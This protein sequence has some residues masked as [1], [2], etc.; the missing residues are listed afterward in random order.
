MPNNIRQ[1]VFGATDRAQ[2]ERFAESVGF[3]LRHLD[4]S[5][6]EL[7]MGDLRKLE[8]ARTLAT[9]AKTLLLDEIFAGPTTGEIAMIADLIKGPGP[10]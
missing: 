6:A 9:G 2:E 10:Q 7:S 1:L 4:R 5:A 3:N 8:F